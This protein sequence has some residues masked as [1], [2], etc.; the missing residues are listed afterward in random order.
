VYAVHDNMFTIRLKET[1]RW[2]EQLINDITGRRI[3]RPRRSKERENNG[4]PASVLLFIR[5]IGERATG[6]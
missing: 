2:S 3:G 4:I 6:E 5:P 1:S